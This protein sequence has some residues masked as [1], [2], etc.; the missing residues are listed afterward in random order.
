MRIQNRTLLLFSMLFLVLG[1][2][3]S[4]CSNDDDD[5]S[6]NVMS[7]F[8]CG[9]MQ[10]SLRSSPTLT[11]FSQLNIING[12][13]AS[14]SQWPWI[15]ALV[16]RGNGIYEGFH[17]GGTLIHPNWVLTAAH[18]INGDSVDVVLGTDSL[19][20]PLSTMEQIA[21]VEKIPH[22]NYNDVTTEN[23]IALYRLATPSS[24][25][26]ASIDWNNRGQ[27][28]VASQ[29]AGWGLT[30]PSGDTASPSLL[31]V[32]LPIVPQATCNQTMSSYLNQA[33]PIYPGMMCA[34]Y[35]E[36]GRDSCSGDSGGP[37]LVDG[38]ITGLVS[39]G[40]TE[41]GVP[42]AYGVYTRVSDYAAWISSIICSRE[43]S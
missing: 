2:F 43:A 30:N 38:Y 32:T 3:L 31:Q 29:V 1:T 41:C 16:Y 21:V 9:D 34:G 6:P 17:C 5:D 15:A 22:P 8:R 39:W 7:Q 35:I 19:T 36:G 33:D 4:A 25:S 27:A 11:D 20:N 14:L 28:G 18:C 40:P 26:P 12:E 23:D 37:L 10:G 13:P 42:G 24:K